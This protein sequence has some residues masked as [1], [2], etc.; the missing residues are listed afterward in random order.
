MIVASSGRYLAVSGH[1]HETVLPGVPHWHRVYRGLC[2]TSPDGRGCRPRRGG[3]HTVNVASITR[4]RADL[5]RW[6]WDL[7]NTPFSGTLPQPCPND[8]GLSGRQCP[9]SRPPG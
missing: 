7:A 1:D 6:L 8:G 9:R 3:G 5:A 2:A 4:R